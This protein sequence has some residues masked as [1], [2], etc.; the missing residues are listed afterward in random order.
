MSGKTKRIC[1]CL[2][3]NNPEHEK[4]IQILEKKENVNAFLRDA[5]ISYEKDYRKDIL[6]REAAE[7]IAQENSAMLLEQIKTLLEQ[8]ISQ[9]NDDKKMDYDNLKKI[10]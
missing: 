9:Q 2:Y 10:F 4:I 6:T 8:S 3:K 1:F 5:V 7:S